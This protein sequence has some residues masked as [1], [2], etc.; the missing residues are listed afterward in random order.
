M[1]LTH[2]DFNFPKFYSDFFKTWVWRALS[3]CLGG[4]CIYLVLYIL[5]YCMCVVVEDVFWQTFPHLPA[6]SGGGP[7]GTAAFSAKRPTQSEDGPHIRPDATAGGLRGC[8]TEHGGSLAGRCKSRE[9]STINLCYRL[10][11]I[12]I[13][14]ISLFVHLYVCVHT[15]ITLS[16]TPNMCWPTAFKLGIK[17]IPSTVV[18]LHYVFPPTKGGSSMWGLPK[19]S[20][21]PQGWSLTHVIHIRYETCPNLHDNLPLWHLPV[22][23]VRHHEPWSLP[24]RHN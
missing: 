20:P 4:P 12:Y 5:M 2:I 9:V 17:I 23:E 10:H 21:P 3:Q 13:Y 18:V 7:I 6:W 1:I 15:C 24:P 14:T 22:W 19:T 8:S 16:P 11:I